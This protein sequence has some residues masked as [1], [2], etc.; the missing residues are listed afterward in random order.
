MMRICFQNKNEESVKRLWQMM[1]MCVG[2]FP[3][4][5]E[6]EFFLLHFLVNALGSE[7]IV[8]D[9]AKYAYRRVEGIL[10]QGASGFVPT[11][12]EIDAYNNRPPILVER[13]LKRNTCVF[14]IKWPENYL[15]YALL[16]EY[17]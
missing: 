6:F 9:Y 4:S 11:V 7:G 15:I 1:C 3:P 14:G 17:L 13:M 12:E 2:T 5:A 10:A 16:R 8:A